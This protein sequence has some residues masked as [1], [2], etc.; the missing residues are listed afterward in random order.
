MAVVMAEFPAGQQGAAG[1]FTFLARTLGVVAGVLG[2]A[3]LFATRRL[4]IGL[5]PA[6]SEA[7]LAAGITVALAAMMAAA[8]RRR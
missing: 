6:A 8:T 4:S 7:F 5:A 3:A 2:W 1:G